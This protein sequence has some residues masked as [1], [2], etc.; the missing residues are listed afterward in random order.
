MSFNTAFRSEMKFTWHKNP[1][2]H[3]HGDCGVPRESDNEQAIIL[4]T[5]FPEGAAGAVSLE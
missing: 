3:P 5:I 1:G 2:L 4:T